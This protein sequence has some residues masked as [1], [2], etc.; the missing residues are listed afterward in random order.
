MKYMFAP[1][2]V[3]AYNRPFSLQQ[4]LE[5]LSKNKEAIESELFVFIDGPKSTNES[6]LVDYVEEI[7]NS[8]S[9]FFK[10]LT[11]FKSELNNGLVKSIRTGITKMRN[12]YSNL[13]IIEED[14]CVSKYFLK[15]MNQG[16]NKYKDNKKIWHLNGFNFPSK[17]EKNDCFFS[18]V[19]FC[20]GWA[21]WNDRWEKYIQD[22]LFHDPFYINNILSEKLIK[23]LNLNSN[24][25][26]FSSQIKNNMKGK[27]SWAIFWYVYIFLNKG[28]CLTPYKSITK[29][30]GHDGSGINCKKISEI[31]NSPINNNPIKIFPNHFIED[32]YALEEMKKYIKKTYNLRAKIYRK[33]KNYF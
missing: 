24:I 10:S 30:I 4:T 18:R 11:I 15:Y 16:L 1:I 7:A 26:F 29:N 2:A 25:N 19:M 8:F 31:Q 5:A 28:L 27:Y 23:E 6:H 13:I 22:S 32:K 9:R 21:T 20:W 14:I 17:I 3:F 33:L 12:N